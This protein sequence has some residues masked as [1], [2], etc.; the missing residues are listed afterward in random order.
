MVVLAVRQPYCSRCRSW[1]RTIRN[2]RI[3]GETAAQLAEL[4]GIEIS[5]EPVSARYRMLNCNGGCGPT[6]FEL[7]WEDSS[8]RSV[9]PPIWIDAECRNRMMRILDRAK[10][11]DGPNDGGPENGGD[12][13]DK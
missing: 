13:P 3:D 10:A 1:Y 4:A 5:D 2:G 6:E 9:P 11:D 7:S 8:S 12:E